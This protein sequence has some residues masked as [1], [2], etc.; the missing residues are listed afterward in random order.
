M[1]KAIIGVFILLLGCQEPLVNESY[2]SINY[3][4]INGFDLMREHLASEYDV[5]NSSFLDAKKMS[6][7]DLIIYFHTELAPYDYMIELDRQI[8]EMVRPEG[9]LPLE[10][11]S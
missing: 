10:P 8:A 4:S 5:Q 11:T 3:E 6:Q 1:N 7:Y 2:G 9:V